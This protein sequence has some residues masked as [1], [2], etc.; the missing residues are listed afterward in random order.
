M[1][2]A[3]KM[4]VIYAMAAIFVLLTLLLS[5]INGVN[6]TM[7]AQDADELTQMITDGRGRFGGR[8]EDP[9]QAGGEGTGTQ[10]EGAPAQFFMMNETDGGKRGGKFGMM[11]PDS[12]DVNAS[13]RYFTC[14][15]DQ[16]G[17]GQLVSYNIYA[18]DE[19]EALAWAESLLG[20]PDTGWTGRTYRY[21]VEEK[22]DATYVTVIDQSRELHPA[23]RIL[24]ISVS[25][26]LCF[27]IISF[28][29]LDYA[30]DKL[31]KPL[32]EA[33]RKQKR[34]IADV[35]KEFGV[36]LT[37]INASTEAMERE[38]GASEYANTIDRQVKKMTAL[39]K[40]LGTLAI[41]D[42][43]DMMKAQVNLSDL[44]NTALDAAAEQFAEKQIALS[45][46]VE[47]DV[48]IEADDTAMKQ[49]C[50]ELIENALKFSVSK[51]AFAVSKE[52]GRTVIVASNDTS[53]SDTA[54]E[55]VFDRFTRLENAEN[56]PGAGLGLSKVKEIVKAHNGRVSAAVADGEFTVSIRL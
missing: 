37:V 4:F 29:V 8:P 5:I 33:D 43:K 54:A 27:L 25:G 34:F 26:E 46:S 2:R 56:V 1:K 32:E 7:A 35:Q 13:M 39:V 53:L 45:V 44:F 47:P 50:A 10:P 14:S 19:E 21:R 40:K 41:F 24:I 11:G 52:E 49:L 18:V 3:K 38:N 55:Q 12:P 23:Y 6:Y 31:F 9:P 15:F 30:S 48:L 17:K 42:E 22:K 28:L 20:R 51:A 16:D 36:P